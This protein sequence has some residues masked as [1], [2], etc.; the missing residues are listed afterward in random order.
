MPATPYVLPYEMASCAF[1]GRWQQQVKNRPFA[2]AIA[3]VRVINVGWHVLNEYMLSISRCQHREMVLNTSSIYYYR[4]SSMT[5]KLP[6]GL[7]EMPLGPSLRHTADMES[8]L[9]RADGNVCTVDEFLLTLGSS[10]NKII[11]LVTRLQ[12]QD[13]KY[14]VRPDAIMT[15]L[16][17]YVIN[18]TGA[19]NSY[20][21]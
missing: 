2:R 12:V 14:A 19:M 1:N 8:C 3:D 20:F 18:D 9:N 10:L 6:F 4:M 13:R 16:G 5:E 21:A 11:I 17:F 7:G 15:S